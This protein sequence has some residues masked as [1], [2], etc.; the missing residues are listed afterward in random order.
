MW[1]FKQWTKNSETPEHSRLAQE[2]VW[3]FF[4]LRRFG[5]KVGRIKG[6]SF[7][8][9]HASFKDIFLKYY[10]ED[11]HIPIEHSLLLSA[12]DSVNIE[13]FDA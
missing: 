3:S 1:R 9:E 8:R 5:L 6:D 12:D 13:N 7:G 2:L 4:Y 10:E 11:T